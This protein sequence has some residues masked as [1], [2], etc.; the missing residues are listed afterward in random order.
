VN[1]K[2]P[3]L[4]RRNVEAF[5]SGGARVFEYWLDAILF[6]IVAPPMVDI[7]R[8][9]LNFYAAN[10]AHT[11]G[12]LAT[13]SLPFIAPNLNAY[14]FARLSWNPR[15]EAA[16]IR[17]AFCGH[18]FQS[19]LHMPGYFEAL[20]RAFALDLD[21]TPEEAFL[22][23]RGTLEETIAAPPS[24]IGSPF[25]VPAGLVGEAQ[26]RQE[27][28]LDALD[29][30][31]R[32]FA[33]MYRQPGEDPSQAMLHEECH[34]FLCNARLNL[35]MASLDVR[36]SQAAGNARDVQD[37]VKHARFHLMNLERELRG[38]V[39]EPYVTNT[40]LLLWLF[41]G[42]ALDKAEDD[43]IAGDGARRKRLRNR[44]E[45]ARQNF[46]RMGTLWTV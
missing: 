5:P 26:A 31:E 42:L 7:I 30:A 27:K 22:K 35:R 1:A 39:R 45:T 44:L 11:V 25:N 23:G 14:A 32:I 13:G 46:A 29:E 10:G 33:Q 24:D 37:A 16:A 18:V 38:F 40:K 17:Q 36:G 8:R 41:L 43:L 3:G 19:S 15:I 12:A 9:D 28:A 4:W 2:Y 21:L 20:E 34:R 6:K